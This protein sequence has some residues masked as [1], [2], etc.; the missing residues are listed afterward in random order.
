MRS[1]ICAA[2]LAAGPALADSEFRNGDD[3]VR[4]SAEPCKD[5]KVL[6]LIESRGGVGTDYRA[7]SAQVNGALYA[8]CWQPIFDKQVVVLVYDD[9]DTGM[10]PFNALKPVK[11]V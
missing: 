10:I 6:A 9:G 1:L 4:I 5:A 11:S 7:A 3:F 2:I 8:G